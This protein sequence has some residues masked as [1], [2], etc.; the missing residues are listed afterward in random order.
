MQT[1]TLN[2]GTA[3]SGF[4]A[5]TSPSTRN[6]WL[7]MAVNGTNIDLELPAWE[8]GVRDATRSVL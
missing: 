1:N 7:G 4:R 6:G 5:N 2:G 8:V 3:G